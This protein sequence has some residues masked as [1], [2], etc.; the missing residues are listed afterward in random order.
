MSDNYSNRRRFGCH[1]SIPWYGITECHV[2]TRPKEMCL[3]AE[4]IIEKR[5]PLEERHLKCMH[6]KEIKIRS[7]SE[8]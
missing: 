4:R 8:R 6:W 1:G 3:H 5:I 2:D 7:E